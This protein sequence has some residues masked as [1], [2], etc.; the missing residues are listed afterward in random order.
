MQLF[1]ELCNGSFLFRWDATF[2]MR[3]YSMLP[4]NYTNSEDVYM[5]FEQS[6]YLAPNAMFPEHL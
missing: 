5:F 2:V 3:K 4:V 6:L 1:S